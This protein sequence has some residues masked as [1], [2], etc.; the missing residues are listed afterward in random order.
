[1]REGLPSH[2]RKRTWTTP[3]GKERVSYQ[4]RIDLGVVDGR[5]RQSVR[6]GFRTKAAAREAL[7]RELEARESGTYARPS[8]E[9]FAD[10]VTERWL[11]MIA[12]TRRPTTHDLYARMMRLYVLPALGALPLQSVRPADV[13]ALYLAL[14]KP[15]PDGRRQALGARSLHN[16]A[17]VLHGALGHAYRLQL[18]ASNAATGITP[19]R[20]PELIEEGEPSHWTAAQVAEFLDHVDG[21]CCSDRAIEEVRTRRGPRGVGTTRYTYRRQITAD[22]MQRALWYVL[23]T[24]GA[25]RGEVC[26]LRWDD[27]DEVAGVL[28]IRRSRVSAGGR[29]VESAPK[30]RRGHRRIALDPATLQV[31]SEWRR[32]QR[33]ERMRAGPAWEDSDDH[34]FTHLVYFTKPVRHGVPLEP[35]WVSMAFRRIVKDS[36]LPPIRLH[37]LRHSWA[38]AALEAG[39]HLRAVADHL[40]H[41]DTAVTDRTYMH[42]VRRVQDVTALRVAALI[43]SRR[44]GSR[45]V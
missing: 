8:R 29:T 15:S 42:T 40:G 44:R 31:L 25:R 39:E 26:G 17:T 3:D 21:V 4:Y 18:V 43:A 30:T 32:A 11:P 9:S 27:L 13:E 45:R 24:T 33:R 7:R 19:P 23:A 36:G 12:A 10:Y 28:S 16:V 35:G 20:A 41:A 2:V 6:G 14:A 5:R 37:G 34:V 22:P 38:T 1:M